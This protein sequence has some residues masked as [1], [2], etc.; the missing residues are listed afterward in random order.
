MATVLRSIWRLDTYQS[1]LPVYAIDAESSL[2]R[3][4]EQGCET[5]RI[6]VQADCIIIRVVALVGNPMETKFVTHVSHFVLTICRC[7]PDLKLRWSSFS[8]SGRTAVFGAWTNRVKSC[9]AVCWVVRALT[10][11]PIHRFSQRALQ[12]LHD[13]MSIGVV[14]YRRAFARSPDQDEL[15][16]PSARSCLVS[17]AC[18]HCNLVGARIA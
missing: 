14:V 10:G 18:S 6:Q 1:K 2:P 12:Y 5:Y 9:G 11:P 8:R 7:F 3:L 4:S 15:C 16:L 17:T 13:A